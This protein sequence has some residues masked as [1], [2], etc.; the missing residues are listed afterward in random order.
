M[1]WET[2]EEVWGNC[3][4]PKVWRAQ[5]QRLFFFSFFLPLFFFRTC[6]E[7]GEGEKAEVDQ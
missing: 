1:Q 7:K 6:V 5:C 3:K 2:L 4:A